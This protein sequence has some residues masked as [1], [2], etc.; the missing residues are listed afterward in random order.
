MEDDK[1]KYKEGISAHYYYCSNPAY[2]RK[3]RYF[4]QIKFIDDYTKQTYSAG[5]VEVFPNVPT[6][7]FDYFSLLIN[8]SLNSCY[9]TFNNSSFTRPNGNAMLYVNVSYFPILQQMFM[10]FFAEIKVQ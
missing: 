7:D 6:A 10:A 2:V 8:V 1:S 4:S 9:I 3:C 5:T